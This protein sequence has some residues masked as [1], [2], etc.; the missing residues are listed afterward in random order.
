M[1]M[2]DIF[3]TSVTA[4]MWQKW[5]VMLPLSTAVLSDHARHFSNQCGNYE[6]TKVVHRNQSDVHRNWSDTWPCI[7]AN[8]L[9]PSSLEHTHTHKHTHTHTHTHTRTHTCSHTCTLNHTHSLTNTHMH[10][11]IRTHAHTCSLCALFIY[12]MFLIIFLYNFLGVFENWSYK[13]NSW[14]V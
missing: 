10:A 3:Q 8:T 14:Y 7:R 4:V 6:V 13:N 12:S 5:R 2:L 11:H 9:L 1:I